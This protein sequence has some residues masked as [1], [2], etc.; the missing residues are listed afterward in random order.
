MKS[1]K[2]LQKLNLLKFY[3][4]HSGYNSLGKLNN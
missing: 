3:N 4:E 2:M 1:T